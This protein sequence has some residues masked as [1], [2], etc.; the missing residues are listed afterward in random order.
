MVEGF[1]PRGRPCAEDF[2]AVCLSKRHIQINE[3][4]AGSKVINLGVS[5]GRVDGQLTVSIFEVHCKIL[6]KGGELARA[7]RKRYVCYRRFQKAR[8]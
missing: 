3:K 2:G 6:I 5:V 1:S 4:S 8:N 7:F